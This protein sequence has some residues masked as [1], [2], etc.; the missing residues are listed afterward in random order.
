M[1]FNQKISWTLLNF[2]ANAQ[3][4]ISPSFMKMPESVLL[5]TEIA[6]GAYADSV[7]EIINELRAIVA[8]ANNVPIETVRVGIELIEPA[9]V[10]LQSRAPDQSR[11]RPMIG[12]AA[13]VARR[14]GPRREG[15]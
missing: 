13:R 6:N 7:V 2:W 3:F 10:G 15:R 11:P 14:A 9:P 1:S 8:V 5:P 4:L 12:R